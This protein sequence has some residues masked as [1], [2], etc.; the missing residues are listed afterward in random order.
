MK[1]PEIPRWAGIGA[2]LCGLALILLGVYRGEVAVVFQ[3]AVNICLEC[4]GIG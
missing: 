3:K 4:I 1:R 2:G